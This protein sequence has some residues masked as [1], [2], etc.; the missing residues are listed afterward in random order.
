LRPA[1]IVRCNNLT[2]DQGEIAR[3]IV[4]DLWRK[5]ALSLIIYHQRRWTPPFELEDERE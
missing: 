5:R 3:Q 4:S 1:D 2:G